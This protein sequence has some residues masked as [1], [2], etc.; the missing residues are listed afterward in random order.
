MQQN[1]NSPRTASGSSSRVGSGADT[2]MVRDY[3]APSRSAAAVNQ[4]TL[5]AQFVDADRYGIPQI[6]AL[7]VPGP[8]PPQAV[9]VTGDTLGAADAEGVRHAGGR[10]YV[11]LT[12]GE[13][14]QVVYD[15][16]SGG[17]HPRLPYQ[18]AASSAVV[19]RMAGACTWTSSTPATH[20]RAMSMPSPTP[21]SVRLDPQWDLHSYDASG[22]G[23][24]QGAVIPGK[25]NYLIGGQTYYGDTQFSLDYYRVG[26]SK[27]HRFNDRGKWVVSGAIAEDGMVQIHGDPA[28][29][30]LYIGNVLARIQVDSAR[31]KYHLVAAAQ[32]GLPGIFLDTGGSRAS[33]VPEMRLDS[34]GDIIS[35]ARKRLGY[36]AVTS[37]M[38]Q[39]LMS[40]MDKQT[41]CYMRQYARQM[42]AF[43]NAHIRNAPVQY[44]DRLIDAHIWRHG[45]PYDRLLL[46][47]RA[48]AERTALPLGIV[49]FDPFQGMATVAPR[50]EGG[51]NVGAVLQNDQL[52]Y[53][54]RQRT[55][56]EQQLLDQWKALNTTDENILR[57]QA[58]EKMYQALLE[59]DG[60]RIIPGGTYGGGQNGFDLVFKGPADDVYVLEVKHAKSGSTSMAKVN[61]D[62][63]MEDGWVARV[64]SRL[65]ANDPGAGQVVE[66]ALRRQ[67]L[68]KVIGATLPDGKL[69]LFK[70][71]MSAVRA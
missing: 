63:Q 4:G 15:P 53:P 62:Y 31:N 32:S 50:R 51:I 52:Y 42:I 48:R 56:D 11:D 5:R 26:M 13:T 59:N 46:G 66:E 64:L 16:A 49:Q 3:G 27:L 47:M 38:S 55:P 10:S 67:R 25:K 58:N 7:D 29:T 30:Y 65:D 14:V 33:W 22:A 9:L 24:T 40:T 69:V 60:Y 17:Y 39:G 41:Y 2:F 8:T 35:A 71:D 34:I 6:S 37:D 57:G 1:T 18:L 23:A 54:Q 20:S 28:A 70:I 44:R 45:Y 43:D 12:T 68:F 36:S 61:P 21:A 19:Q